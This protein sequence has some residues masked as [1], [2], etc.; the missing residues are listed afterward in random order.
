MAAYFI[1]STNI[2]IHIY[3]INS[4]LLRWYKNILEFQTL[5]VDFVRFNIVTA[6]RNA[7]HVAKEKKLIIPRLPSPPDLK[8]C[9]QI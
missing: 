7:L 1:F 9:S 3:S 4:A 8:P 2:V 6:L 5:N